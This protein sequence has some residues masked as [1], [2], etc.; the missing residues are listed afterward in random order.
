MVDLAER[1]PEAALELCSL[2]GEVQA[3]VLVAGGDG[4]VG[5]VLNAVNKLQLKVLCSNAVP[6]SGIL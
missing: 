3:T 1:S 6:F 2:L 4:T 5:W